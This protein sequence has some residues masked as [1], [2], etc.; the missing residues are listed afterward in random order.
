[1]HTPHATTAA[2]AAASFGLGR[3]ISNMSST[4]YA[5]S[6]NDTAAAAFSG[7]GGLQGSPQMRRAD[8]SSVHSCSSNWSSYHLPPASALPQLVLSAHYEQQLQSV[9]GRSGS[10]P[11]A[12]TAGV[13]LAPAV[14]EEVAE[15]TTAVFES[16]CEALPW[17]QQQQ[18][19]QSPNAAVLA[20]AD[21][22]GDYSMHKLAVSSFAA[23]AAAGEQTAAS[24]G[25]SAFAAG[26][27]IAGSSSS[28]RSSGVL[29]SGV[30]VQRKVSFAAEPQMLG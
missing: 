13:L 19:Q 24:S 3:S 21:S 22:T 15:S 2:A 1:L 11:T 8:S 23:A 18:Q 27:G 20:P 10:T 6:S 7:A 12:V 28:M 30:A 29:P 25:G 9:G 16:A 14:E 4:S 17:Q 5:S 26:L